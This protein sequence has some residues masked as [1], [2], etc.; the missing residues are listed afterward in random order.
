MAE[1]AMQQ[2][3]AQGIEIVG[4]EFGEPGEFYP[5][6]NNLFV[7]VPTKN[8]LTFPQGKIFSKSYLLGISSDSGKTWTFV[9]GAGMK[10][11]QP[12]TRC[13]PSCRKN[14]SYLPRKSRDYSQQHVVAV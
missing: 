8:E 9:E 4:S 3:K 1:Q 6:G 5:E 7:I 11:K 10:I 13:S 12:W 2:L 14:L